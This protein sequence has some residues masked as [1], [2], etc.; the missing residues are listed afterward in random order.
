MFADNGRGP[1]GQ[2]TLPAVLIVAETRHD[3]FA[4]GTGV[5]QVSDSNLSIDRSRASA[6]PDSA[7]GFL[8]QHHAV[9]AADVDEF[10]DGA[11]TRSDIRP[12]AVT[13]S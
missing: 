5:N 13:A 6:Y 7:H 1:G 9:F 10:L 2:D 3:D 12:A 8:F 4:A 11:V